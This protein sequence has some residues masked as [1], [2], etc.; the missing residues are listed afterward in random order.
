MKSTEINKSPASLIIN[1]T[2]LISVRH[3]Q[4]CLLR[5][6]RDLDGCFIVSFDVTI[7]VI[8]VLF[9]W[10]LDPLLCNVMFF[11]AAVAV[12][13]KHNYYGKE[14]QKEIVTR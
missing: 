4:K 8:S 9:S 6:N 14:N 12:F 10:A 5:I 13:V 7:K 3:L 1:Q 2:D 11:G